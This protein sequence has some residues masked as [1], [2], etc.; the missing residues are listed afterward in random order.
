MRLRAVLVPGLLLAGFL[1]FA[2]S[3]PVVGLVLAGLAFCLFLGFTGPQEELAVKLPQQQ[4]FER[5]RYW[6][7][8][9]IRYLFMLWLIS[10]PELEAFIHRVNHGYAL[11]DWRL[12]LPAIILATLGAISGLRRASSLSD[13]Q[14]YDW[15][16]EKHGE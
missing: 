10:Q 13:Q 7:G 16:A 4:G 3:L 12:I 5:W 2:R 9:I 6:S 8:Q 1:A 14:I 11:W 15:L